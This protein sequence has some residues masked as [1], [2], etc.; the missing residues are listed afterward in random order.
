MIAFF[1]CDSN[2]EHVNKTRGQTA[3]ISLLSHGSRLN[4]NRFRK[5]ETKSALTHLKNRGCLSKQCLLQLTQ[6]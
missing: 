3:E 5:H 6:V 2:K 4:N 1:F